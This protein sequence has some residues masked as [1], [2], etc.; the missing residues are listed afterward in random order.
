[1]FVYVRRRRFLLPLRQKRVDKDGDAVLAY[2]EK[3]SKDSVEL[4]IM[5]KLLFF[6]IL[7]AMFAVC[8]AIKV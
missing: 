8:L 3:H 4:A 1:M 6:N 5:C 2:C 7:V